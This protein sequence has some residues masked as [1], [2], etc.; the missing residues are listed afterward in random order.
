VRTAGCRHKQTHRD[1]LLNGQPV[2]PRT[3]ASAH[4]QSML[5]ATRSPHSSSILMHP[6]RCTVSAAGT[7]RLGACHASVEGEPCL[8]E[9]VSMSSF[10]ARPCAPPM[11]SP[12]IHSP[13]F[14]SKLHNIR[15]ACGGTSWHGSQRAQGVAVRGL[16]TKQGPPKLHVP[17]KGF[18]TSR[19]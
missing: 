14:D 3:T 12:G 13:D 11:A 2:V 17:G 8:Q 16:H 9:K 19:F 10:S 18:P 7:M 6:T 4:V 15:S 1:Q 5:I